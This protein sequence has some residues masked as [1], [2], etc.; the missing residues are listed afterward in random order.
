M[1]R[2]TRAVDPDDLRDLLEHAP[3]ANVAF[4]EAGAVA[5]LPVA[6]IFR[7]GR[8]WIGIPRESSGPTPQPNEHVALLIDDGCYSLELRGIHIR[9][10]ALPAEQA[11]EG[12][13]LPCEWLQVVPEKIIAWDYGAVREAKDA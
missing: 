8:Y 6:F 9:G 1:K 5:A 7:D 10:Q 13:S 3:Q 2:M 12:A 11:P 4:S